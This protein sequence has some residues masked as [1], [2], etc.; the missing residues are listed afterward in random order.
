M[1]EGFTQAYADT[2]RRFGGTGLGLSISRV[3]VEKLG[4]VLKVESEVGRGSTFSF[5]LT[6]PKAEAPRAKTEDVLDNGSLIGRRI[7]LAEDN[8]INRD[9]ARLMLEEWQVQVDEAPDGLIAVEMHAANAY[10]VIL[11]DIQMPNMNGLEATA[12]IRQHPDSQRAQ[13]PILALTANAF[14]ADNELYLA[15][16]MNDCLAKPFEEDALYQKLVN[17]V[18]S[19]AQHTRSYDLTSLRELARGKQAF[20]DK[21]IRSFLRNIPETVQD[22]R[23]AAG[24]GNWVRVAELVHHIKPNLVQLGVE[25]VDEA[26]KQ[27]EQARHGIG[28]SETR[29]AAVGH[30]TTRLDRVVQEL[31]TELS[32]EGA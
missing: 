20:V 24:D 18:A 30:L 31:P 12:R 22:L 16:G 27:L 21:I 15:A 6:L 4:G 7:L 10:D 2:T 3:L 32:S 29:L 17:L 28:A 23:L 5:T 1:F 13:V 19:A 26:V 8:E 14:R 25:G 9:V 11:M